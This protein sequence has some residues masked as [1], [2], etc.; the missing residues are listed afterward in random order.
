MTRYRLIRFAQA[1]AAALA[2]VI[3]GSALAQATAAGLASVTRLLTILGAC[4]VAASAGWHGTAILLE[5]HEE[6]KRAERRHRVP[7]ADRGTPRDP[8]TLEQ[9]P[10]AAD[11]YTAPYRPHA[12]A[13]PYPGQAPAE[14]VEQADA[15]WPEQGP[16]RV[17]PH[18]DLYA[19]P[20]SPA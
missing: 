9:R 14:W 8:G 13:G 19:H 1:T 11:A 17:D 5:R 4:G 3:L 7:R 15:G 18:E 20:A 16:A 10:A 12:D 6:R 2:V